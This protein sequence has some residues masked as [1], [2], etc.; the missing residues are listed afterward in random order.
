MKIMKRAQ[1]KGP[2]GA[3][4]EKD[5]RRVAQLLAETKT[6]GSAGDRIELLSRHF[7]GQPYTT[8][9]L[10][11]S[12]NEPEVFVTSLDGFDCVTYLETVL[13]LARASSTE[14]FVEELRRIRYEG[15]RIDWS[16]RNHYM[17]G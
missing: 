6:K 14:D 2:S 12:A 1:P 4:K 5:R 10:I 8:N 7:L 17:T 13:A 9:P 11:G 3:W 16:R 15:G